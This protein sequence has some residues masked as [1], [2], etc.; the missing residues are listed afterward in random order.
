MMKKRTGSWQEERDMAEERGMEEGKLGL[1]DEPNEA[2]QEEFKRRRQHR[3]GV[4]TERSR[5]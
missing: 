5:R 3:N 4:G 1:V 2:C